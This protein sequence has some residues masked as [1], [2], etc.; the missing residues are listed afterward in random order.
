MTDLELIQGNRKVGLYDCGEGWD[1]DYN[2]NNPDDVALL[3]FDIYELVNGEWEPLPD[4]SYCTA[5]PVDTDPAILRKA[6][7]TIMDETAGHERVKRIAEGL[8]WLSPGF[9]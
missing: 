1:G 2:P 4:A 6:L 8:S 5:L 3:R 7:E 9:F